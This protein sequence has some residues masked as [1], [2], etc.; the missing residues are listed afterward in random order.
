[1]IHDEPCSNFSILERRDTLRRRAHKNVCRF[2]VHK[3]IH[4][5]LA[6]TRAPVFVLILEAERRF[7]RCLQ[8]VTDCRAHGGV[9]AWVPSGDGQY[10]DGRRIDSVSFR[11]KSVSV[12]FPDWWSRVSTWRNHRVVGEICEKHRSAGPVGEA[13]TNEKRRG[14][15][16]SSSSSSVRSRT[17]SPAGPVACVFRGCSLTGGRTCAK[18]RRVSGAERGRFRRAPHRAPNT[19][20]LLR[21]ASV[22]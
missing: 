5:L 1:M 20:T 17:R 11:V 12:L 3:T 6:A 16:S 19:D 10:K 13:N 18:T 4:V 21:A 8:L 2:S 7:A 22:I 14:P 9:P 15:S